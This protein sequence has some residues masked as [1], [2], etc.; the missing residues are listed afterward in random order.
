MV[1][2]IFVALMSGGY[3][4][5]E[6]FSPSE[7]AI[8][9]SYCK[10]SKLGNTVF[11][12]KNKRSRYRFLRAAVIQ[13]SIA[14]TFL[15]LNLA[16]ALWGDAEINNLTVRDINASYIACDLMFVVSMGIFYKIYR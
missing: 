16:L 2:L 10:L 14:Y 6:Q 12:F 9:W 11:I 5:D 8:S 15:M 13:Q 3:R 1:I 4:M 7:R